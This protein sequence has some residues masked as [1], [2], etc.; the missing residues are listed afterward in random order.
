MIPLLPEEPV[1]RRLGG[2][3]LQWRPGGA[4]ASGGSRRGTRAGSSRDLVGLRFYET[5]DDIRDIDWATTIRFD[6]AHVRQYRQ[7]T[8]GTLLLLLDAS[9]SMGFGEPAKLDY[10]VAVACA[11]G[12]LALAHHDRVGAVV[13]SNRVVASL[14]VARG[15]GQWR[16]L[17]A[18]VAGVT[19]AGP[20]SFDDI[21]LALPRLGRPRG[22]VVVLSDFVPLEAFSAGL[23]RLARM[24]LSIVALQVLSQQELVPTV[25]GD[26]VLADVETGETRSGWVGSAERAAYRS[27]LDLLRRQVASACEEVGARHVEVSTSTSVLRC[28]QHTLVHAGILTRKTT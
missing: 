15:Y 12:F 6:R 4:M 24:N 7:E 25:D 28:L 17:A 13:F 26:I 18:M 2:L 19:A 1:L 5:G 11:L 27:S 21:V 10:A 8:E 16:T 3:R 14:P 20:T 23:T 22:T 9:A